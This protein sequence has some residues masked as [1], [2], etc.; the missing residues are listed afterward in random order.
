MLVNVLWRSL[1]LIAMLSAIILGGWIGYNLGNKFIRTYTPPTTPKK[2]VMYKDTEEN[3]TSTKLSQ[4]TTELSKLRKD[5]DVPL[6]LLPSDFRDQ[7]SLALAVKE[8]KGPKF[9]MKSPRK[10]E[11]RE[12]KKRE[13]QVRKPKPKPRPKKHEKPKPQKP[14]SKPEPSKPE[15]LNRD[16]YYLQVGVFSIKDNAEYVKRKL[17]ELGLRNVSVSV[18]VKRNLKLY[19]VSVGPFTNPQQARKVQEVLN[20]NGYSA[21][22]YS[23]R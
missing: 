9:K 14:E 10:D 7:R 8:R 6:V 1:L 23:V 12:E 21:M 3:S 22:I 18:L 11:E 20:S 15:N 4:I 17:Q 2:I 16:T 13:K 19:R 5:Y